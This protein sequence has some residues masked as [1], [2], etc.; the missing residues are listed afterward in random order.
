MPPLNCRRAVL[1]EVKMEE[2]KKP[3]DLNIPETE[4]EPE[5]P[6]PEISETTDSPDV[7]ETTAYKEAPR[8]K[9]GSLFFITVTIVIAVGILLIF[10]AQSKTSIDKL[11]NEFADADVPRK[12]EIVGK[13]A[14]TGKRD[15]V[16]VLT[17]LLHAQDNPLVRERICEELGNMGMDLAIGPLR[18]N[19]EEDSDVRVRLKAAWALDR[20]GS[21]KAKKVLRKVAETGKDPFARMRAQF[22]LKMDEDEN[23]VPDLIGKLDAPDPLE[24]RQAIQYLAVRDNPVII[25]ALITALEDEDEDVRISVVLALREKKTPES[26]KALKEHAKTETSNQVLALFKDSK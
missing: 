26:E 16:G 12:M 14:K 8:K 11:S 1:I 10:L 25:P 22:Y 9:F 4:T 3:D 23:L 17:S 2:Q 19:L 7:D 24:R 13:L 5:A 15:A 6:A 20:I 18:Q 21:D